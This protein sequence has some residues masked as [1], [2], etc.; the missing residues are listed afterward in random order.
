VN[1]WKMA[2]VAAGS[3]LALAACGGGSSTAGGGGGTCSPTGGSTSGSGAATV[4]IV[5]D[6]NTVGKF[7]PATVTVTAG[8][9]VEWDF[10]DTSGTPHT[11]TANDGSFESCSQTSG[12]FVVTFSKAGDVQYHCTLHAQMLGTVKVS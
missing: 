9:T 7:D 8:Q 10:A 1:V 12:K 6:P 11:V 3:A 4:K 5:S 2:I